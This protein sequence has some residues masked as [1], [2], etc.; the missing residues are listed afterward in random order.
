[1]TVLRRAALRSGRGAVGQVFGLMSKRLLQL[2]L[3][4]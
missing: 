4:L 3:G 2:L 1:L